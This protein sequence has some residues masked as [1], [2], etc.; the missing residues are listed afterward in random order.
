MSGTAAP[1]RGDTGVRRELPPGIVVDGVRA[2]YGRIE[3]LHGVDL[4]VPPGSVFALLGPNGAGK[5]T[6]L[7]VISGRI[8][9]STGEVRI[10]DR[11]VGRR[12]TEKL[13]RGGLC[14]V[15]EGRGI[16]PNLTVRENLSIWTYR[17]G[18]HA[19]DVEE[20][21]FAAFPR[22]KERRRQMAGTLSG[23]EQ[24]MLAISR[25]LVTDPLVILLDELSMGLAPLIV[26]ELYELVGD[27]ARQG[28]TILLVEQFVTTALAV[29]TRAAIMVHGRIEQEGTPQEMA[30]AALSVY[31][32]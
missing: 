25:A 19:K 16:F 22:L 3:V 31:L 18:L 23:G 5:S 21:T 1:A 24:Q 10:G 9:P 12:P 14:A 32:A 28:M 13:A 8:R 30:D 29:A 7:K 15:P 27:L 4:V 26:A 6:L 2:A 20:K 17:G 11:A